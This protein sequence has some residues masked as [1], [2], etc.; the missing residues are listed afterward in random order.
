MT[1]SLR[2]RVRKRAAGL[3]SAT[4]ASA[5]NALWNPIKCD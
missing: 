3:L 2:S 5:C 4:K 1:Y